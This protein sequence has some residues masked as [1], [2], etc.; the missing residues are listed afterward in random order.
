MSLIPVLNCPLKL[1]KAI[2]SSCLVSS[3]CLSFPVDHGCSKRG[4]AL[5]QP[6]MIAHLSSLGWR[7]GRQSLYCLGQWLPAADV[8]HRLSSLQ[9]LSSICPELK[10]GCQHVPFFLT[11]SPPR[12][13]GAH[14]SGPLGRGL[15]RL[16]NP[17][18][19]VLL[20]NSLGICICLLAY[21][22]DSN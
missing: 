7:L 14:A 19:T 6:K 20:E 4:S 10:H 2:R 13:P 16:S 11:H 15:P 8:C 18:A 5:F 3:G 9:S 1:K 12:E 17:G 22:S 21:L